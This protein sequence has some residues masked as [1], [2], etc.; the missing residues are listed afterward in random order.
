MRSS[1]VALRRLECGSF[2]APEQTFKRYITPGTSPPPQ[3][4]QDWIAPKVQGW[5]W[6]KQRWRALIQ[7]GLCAQQQIK[8]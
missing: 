1:S 6:L 8:C 4:R 2:L 7:P 5:P 3:L